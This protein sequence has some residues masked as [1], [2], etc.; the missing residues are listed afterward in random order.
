MTMKWINKTTISVIGLVI[1]W[2][3]AWGF[4]K[5]GLTYTPPLLFAGM[6]MFI[7]SLMLCVVAI[8]T[9][10]SPE[11][12]K[13]WRIY[14]I[15]GL[16]NALL[17]F[18]FQTEGL[19]YLP[20]GLLAVL[21]YL[22]PI[23]VGV[24]AW[25]WLGE[26]LYRRKVAGLI[27]GFVGVGAVSW[28]S[29]NGHTSMLGIVFALAAGIAWGI[30]TVY[31]KRAQARVPM[32]WLVALQFLFGG[33]GMLVIGSLTESWASIQ[34][35]GTYWVCLIYLTTIGVAFSWLVWFSLVQRGEVSRVASYIFFV[36]ILSVAIGIVFLHE[37]F[38]PY[39]MVGLAFVSV[40]IYLVNSRVQGEK[41]RHAVPDG[42]VVRDS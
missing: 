7:G 27:C 25:G 41:L 37:A 13:N 3:L 2:S 35:T 40:G 20:S 22:Q 4:I 12:R 14:M 17:F 11:F 24:L 36:P 38:T 21:I 9:K 19:E 39:L 34:W 29:M 28:E 5:V 16:F 33:A 18:G 26:P 10:Q 32:M 6:R 31:S 42:S 8:L 23:V 30:G 1:M 15:S